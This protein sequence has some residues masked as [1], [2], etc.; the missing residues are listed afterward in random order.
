MAKN[1]ETQDSKPTQDKSRAQWVA[2]NQNWS[3]EEFWNDTNRRENKQMEDA[4]E[5]ISQVQKE[6]I[7]KTKLIRTHN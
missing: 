7:I 5:K 1:N 4:I 6:M 2:G 3:M